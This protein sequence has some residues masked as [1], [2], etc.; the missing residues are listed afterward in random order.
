MKSAKCI[1]D[2]KRANFCEYN[3]LSDAAFDYIK[4][5]KQQQVKVQLAALFGETLDEADLAPT[6]I[7]EIP[8][9]IVQRKLHE[10]LNQ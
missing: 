4:V 3:H 9:Q 5:H 8:G 6:A 10:L 1:V 7:Q 2:R